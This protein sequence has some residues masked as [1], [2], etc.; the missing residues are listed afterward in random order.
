MAPPVGCPA[1]VTTGTL[2][3]LGGAD[4]PIGIFDST[5]RHLAIEWPAGFA[6]RQAGGRA[7]VVDP[8]GRVIAGVGDVV[9]LLGGEVRP[10]VWLACPLPIRRVIDPA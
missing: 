2:E 1:N 9:E 10:G 4:D 7:V 5:N 8:G 3:Q 6:T